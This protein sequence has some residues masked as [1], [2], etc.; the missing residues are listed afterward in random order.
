M[1]VDTLVLLDTLSTIARNRNVMVTAQ[2]S[3]KAG[4][5]AGTS[6]VLGTMLGGPI[7]LVLGNYLMMQSRRWKL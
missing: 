4:A 3:M 5:I 2:Q 6:V 1:P 7:G